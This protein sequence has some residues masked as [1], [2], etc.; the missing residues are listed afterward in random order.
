MTFSPCGAV[1][2]FLLSGRDAFEGRSIPATLEMVL[3]ADPVNIVDIPELEI[4]A[5]LASLVMQCLAK[6]PADRPADLDLVIERLQDLATTHPWS[7]AAARQWWQTNA[8]SHP[9]PN[10]DAWRQ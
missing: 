5:S 7:Q 8:W 10:F 6:N 2:Y 4:P 3:Q 9:R 1:A